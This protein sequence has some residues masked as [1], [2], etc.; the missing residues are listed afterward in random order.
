[1]RLTVFDIAIVLASYY[2]CI[3]APIRLLGPVR[4]QSDGCLQNEN[5]QGSRDLW[6]VKNV[7]AIN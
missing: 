1:M 7:C 6:P 4:L 3:A 5:E 2:E